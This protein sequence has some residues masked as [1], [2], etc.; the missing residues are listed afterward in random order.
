LS[1][2]F[3]VVAGEY[4]GAAVVKAT[5][6]QPGEQPPE[7]LVRVGNLPVIRMGAVIGT[8]GFWRI[9][10]A[11]R[12]VKM[13]PQKER[14]RRGALQPCNRAVNAFTGPAVYQPDIFL[15]EGL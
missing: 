3:P 7:F 10:R 4:D 11:V 12:V 9:V 14:P 1:Q 8:E 15:L 5:R 2:G 6:S 13:E